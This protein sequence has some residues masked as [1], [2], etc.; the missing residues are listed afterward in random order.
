MKMLKNVLKSA[1]KK[2]QNLAKNHQKA[3]AIAHENAQKC[4]KIRSEK[5]SKFGQK[6]SK[7]MGYSP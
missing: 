2:F 3:W 6:S 7:T 5:I 1:L 4:P